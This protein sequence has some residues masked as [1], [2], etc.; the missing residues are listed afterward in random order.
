MEAILKPYVKQ[1]DKKRNLLNPI[2]RQNPYLH[3]AWRDE[4]GILHQYPNRRERR[5]FERKKNN[6]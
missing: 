4:K 6:N 5:A 3:Q 1:F 2:S